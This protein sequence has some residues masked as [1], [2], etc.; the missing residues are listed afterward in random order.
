M[1]LK[2][3]QVGEGPWGGW[4]VCKVGPL[5]PEGE[6]QTCLPCEA[7]LEQLVRIR[8]E[9]EGG[10]GHHCLSRGGFRCLSF[11]GTWVAQVKCLPSAQVMIQ[12]PGVDGAPG[13]APCSAG[14]LLLLLLP[15]LVLSSLY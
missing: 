1:S 9:L 2:Q 4:V 6:T 5:V 13:R 3:G 11:R 8:T 14:S 12:S 7:D 10:H 15:L